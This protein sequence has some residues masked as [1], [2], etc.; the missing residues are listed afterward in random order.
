MGHCSFECTEPKKIQGSTS[1]TVN[2][3]NEENSDS[4]GVSWESNDS[5]AYMNHI[6]AYQ[7]VSH[8]NQ[9]KPKNT[10]VLLDNQSTVNIFVNPKLLSNIRVS[11]EEMTIHSH[12]GARA[13]KM[14]G[15]LQGYKQPVWYDPR[16][17]TNILVMS[18]VAKLHKITF[19]SSNGNK[20]IVNLQ[21]AKWSLNNV[22]MAYTIMTANSRGSLF[23]QT[24]HQNK[25]RYTKRQIKSAEAARKLQNVLQFPT[26]KE[27]KKDDSRQHHKELPRSE[28]GY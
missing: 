12:G 7:T 11:Q 15:S 26:T 8:M 25:K 18:N 14:I 19:D 1:T 22:A 4:A 6:I 13:T 2:V 21:I 27:Y 3:K 20:F 23:V 17:I 24:V 9:M 16:G 28:P 10:W 5:D